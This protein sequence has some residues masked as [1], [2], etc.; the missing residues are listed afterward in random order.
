MAAI[1]TTGIDWLRVSP[2]YVMRELLGWGV[3]AVFFVAITVVVWVFTAEYGPWWLIPGA[4]A[5]LALVQIP[6]AWRR[7]RAIGYALRRDDLVFTKGILYQRLVAVPYGRLQM[8]DVQRDPFDRILGLASVKTMTAS[9]T[10]DVQIPGLTVAESERLRDH[11]IAVAET[12]RA[13]L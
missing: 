13:G 11:L 6:F 12:R 2:K 9:P 7:A 3:W 8:V 10:T 4:M 1:E 5:L